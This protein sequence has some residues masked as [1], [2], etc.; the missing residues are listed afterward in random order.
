MKK[1][2]EAVGIYRQWKADMKTHFNK[3]VG[4]LHL[5]ANF[6]TFFQSDGG[7]E[8]TGKEFESELAH[9]GS[10]HLTTAADTP[11]QNEI[12]ECMCY[13]RDNRLRSKDAV[14]S[15]RGQVWPY[16]NKQNASDEVLSVLE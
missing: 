2:S 6:P 14:Y 4:G 7:G 3:E 15:Q 16:L 11:E 8:Y 1:K 12:S 13:D 10:I 5:S 9:Q